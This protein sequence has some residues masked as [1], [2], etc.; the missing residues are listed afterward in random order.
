MNLKVI[1]N[2]VFPFGRCFAI[3]VWPF[4]FS[5]R[6]MSDIDMNHEN[7]HA[8]Q[9]LE[10]LIASSLG[11]AVIIILA[12]ISLFWIFLAPFVYFVLYGAEYVIRWLLY[13]KRV[14]A[15]ANI[16]FEQE[17]YKYQYNL[18]YEKVRKP[19]EWMSFL[20]K[21]TFGIKNNTK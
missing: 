14:E 1:K 16:S 11:L 5:K 6:D 8:C 2:K 13:K 18:G 10:V 20:V 21:K 3:T 12:D 9:Q 17:A 19:F 4:V 15:Y 7:I